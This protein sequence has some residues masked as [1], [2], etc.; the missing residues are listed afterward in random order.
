MKVH[1]LATVRR[2][3]LL[4]AAALVFR[5]L[6]VGFP[7]LPIY[8]W[9]N[10]LTQSSEK[11]I[12]ALAYHWGCHFNNLPFTS[13]D[14]W[15]ETIIH[16]ETEPCWICD[17][18]MVFWDSVEDW[19]FEMLA[20]RHECAWHEP[21]T[22]T[23]RVDRLHTCLMFVNPAALRVAI[24]AYLG[25]FPAP[26]GA[27]AQV[28]LIRQTFIPRTNQR[29]LFYDSTAGLYQAIGGEAFT[30]EQNAC[31]DHLNCGTYANEL[32]GELSGLQKAHEEI[33]KDISKAKGLLPL[34]NQF[35][36]SHSIR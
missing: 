35:Y 24:R 33:F 26:W 1:I 8:I 12:K 25:R 27:T 32:T 34:Q 5:T 18:D 30:E 11:E 21:W 36:Q 13:H 22:D 16:T 19:K 3:D 6:R 31:F 9:G 20:G 23:D 17:T 15:I 14:A 2:S 4:P 29:P 10:S 28:P 7:T